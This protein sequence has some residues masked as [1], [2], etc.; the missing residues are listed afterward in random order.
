MSDYLNRLV[1]K[2]LGKVDRIKSYRSAMSEDGVVL[3]PDSADGK[4]IRSVL[5]KVGSQPKKNRAGIGTIS[6]I[7]SG[8][9]KGRKS[10]SSAQAGRVNS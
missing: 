9:F 2:E 10:R 4:I 3:L 8:W 1:G 5:V 6:Q 7:I